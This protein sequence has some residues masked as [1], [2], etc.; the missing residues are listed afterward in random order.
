MLHLQAESIV[1]SER[2]PYRSTSD[3]LAKSRDCPDNKS[4][5]HYDELESYIAAFAERS[6][7][8]ARQMVDKAMQVCQN[9]AGNYWTLYN[10]LLIVSSICCLCYIGEPWR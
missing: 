1:N 3:V 10:R 6:L 5:G 8:Q 9:L 7:S 4:V 2:P